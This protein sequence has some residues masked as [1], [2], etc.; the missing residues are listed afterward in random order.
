MA[1]RERRASVARASRAFGLRSSSPL[2]VAVFVAAA[3][4]G[5]RRRYKSWTL[6]PR[7]APPARRYGMP[8]SMAATADYVRLA[9]V[10]EIS[11]TRSRLASDFTLTWFT[12]LT[13]SR[14]SWLIHSSQNPPRT[15]QAHRV[16]S[17]RRLP[18]LALAHISF[19]PRRRTASRRPSSR[20]HGRTSAT[21]TR[22][23]SPAPARLPR[24][25]ACLI[26]SRDRLSPRDLPRSPRD[27]ERS[28]SAS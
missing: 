5:V 8:A 23:S 9:E 10:R 27:L 7:R 2:Q 11:S 22:R 26:A 28:P 18:R 21:A 3:S 12:W 20:S 16:S 14:G 24:P 6:L 15:L 1:S 19:T 25:R 4:C 13:R 17:W